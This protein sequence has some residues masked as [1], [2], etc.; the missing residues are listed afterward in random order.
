[1]F[2]GIIKFFRSLC[3]KFNFSNSD[4][5]S[6]H[7]LVKPDDDNDCT[8]EN[9]TSNHT[10]NNSA[11]HIPYDPYQQVLDDDSDFINSGLI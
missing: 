5:K 11:P 7:H 2:D 10:D 1:M 9:G 6:G 8:A 3:S 4:D